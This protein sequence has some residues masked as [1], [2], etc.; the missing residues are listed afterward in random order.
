M[1]GAT[2]HGD[3]L[4]DARDNIAALR[5]ILGDDVAGP[6][7]NAAV[8]NSGQHLR[9]ADEFALAAELFRCWTLVFSE[10]EATAARWASLRATPKRARRRAS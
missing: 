7:M 1:S 3:A 9:T 5:A 10:R 6:L 4:Q 8:Y 2:E